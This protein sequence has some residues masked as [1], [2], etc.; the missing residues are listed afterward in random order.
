MSEEK[1][2]R[3]DPQNR[4]GNLK[5]ILAAMI[6]EAG[7]E[8]VVVDIGTGKSGSV[9]RIYI[10]A[11]GGVQHEDCERVSRLVVDYLDGCEEEGHAWF[12]DR[13]FIEVSSPGLE[14]PLFTI[15]HYRRFTGRLA[16]VSLR[17]RKKITGVIDSVDDAGNVALTPKDGHQT[18]TVPFDEIKRGNLLFVM[19]KG[20]KKGDSKKRK[21]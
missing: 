17:N 6:E 20:E 16:C 3:V 21:K 10:D 5:R 8:C 2:V 13:Y 11:P 12:A 14:R 4:L 1:S 19:E 9:L 18:E 15:D 7:F